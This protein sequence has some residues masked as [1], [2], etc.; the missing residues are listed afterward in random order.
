M[1]PSLQKRVG[2]A[3]VGVSL[4]LAIVLQV[5]FNALWL[6]GKGPPRSK[7]T[8]GVARPNEPLYIWP[9]I[10]VWSLPFFFGVGLVSVGYWRGQRA[11]R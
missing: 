5:A 7:Q 3:V 1:T 4:A 9:T 2:W 8:K 10:V 6:D 11:P